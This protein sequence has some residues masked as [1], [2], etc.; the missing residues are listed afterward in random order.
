MGIVGSCTEQLLQATPRIDSCRPN[1]RHIDYVPSIRVMLLRAVPAQPY[2]NLKHH[3]Q[4]HL[5]YPKQ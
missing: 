2:Q 5:D 4:M 1:L 3:Q